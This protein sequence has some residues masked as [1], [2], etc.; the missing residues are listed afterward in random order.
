VIFDRSPTTRQLAVAGILGAFALAAATGFWLSIRGPDDGSPDDVELP[1]EAT[2]ELEADWSN[3]PAREIEIAFD[4]ERGPIWKLPD[5]SI[6]LTP[7]VP[8][9]SEVEWQHHRTDRGTILVGR[10]PIRQG[11]F[12]AIWHFSPGDPQARLTI[13]VSDLSLPTLREQKLTGKLQIPEGKLRASDGSLG[14][15]EGSAIDLPHDISPWEPAWFE[16]KREDRRLAIRGWTGDGLSLTRSADGLELEFDLWRPEAHAAVQRCQLDDDSP[17][18]IDL[19]TTAT[20]Q[21]GDAP[22][23]FASRFPDRNRAALAPI[24]DLPSAHPDTTLHGG[25]PKGP[26][27]WADRAR[28]LAFGHSNPDDPRY[29]NGGLLGHGLGGTIVVPADWGHHEAVESFRKDISNPALDVATRGGSS[30]EGPGFETLLGAEKT[31]CSS[32]LE[33]G[34]GPTVLAD[35]TVPFRGNLTSATAPEPED[36]SPRLSPPSTPIASSARLYRLDGTRPQLVDELLSEDSIDRLQRR[37]GL[38]LFSTPL[39]GT[40]NPLIPAAKEALLSPERHGEWTLESSFASALVNL[41]INSE[42]SPLAVRSVAGLVD[43]WRRARR[44][45]MR[46]NQRGELLVRSPAERSIRGFTLVLDGAA[47]E[48]SQIS[49]DGAESTVQTTDHTA[50]PGTPTPQTWISWD[51]AS[52]ET[53]RLSFGDRPSKLFDAESVDWQIQSD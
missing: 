3:A 53:Y 13:E 15:I 12:R 42:T 20:F 45:M 11:E 6:A 21:F 47:L 36:A 25:S 30:G 8:D 50:G 51:L 1:V 5:T 14:V 4:S 38:A 10:A 44:T 18:T 23:V 19:R 35:D 41:E 28:T 40:R 29:G 24:F 48:A 26:R 9:S 16:W 32:L 52:D 46:W 22:T 34:T 39:L 7:I 17:S 43:H 31:T 37:R 2:H 49:V 33:A 27:D